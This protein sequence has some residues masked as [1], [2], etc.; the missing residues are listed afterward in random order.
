MKQKKSENQDA[1]ST[2][3]L[4]GRL[5]KNYASD[6]HP[7]NMPKSAQNAGQPTGDDDLDIAELLKKYL[8]DVETS[9][10]SMSAQSDS[11][12]LSGTDR[13]MQVDDAATTEFTAVR[14][15]DAPRHGERFSALFEN[16]DEFIDEPLSA[17]S[18]DDEDKIDAAPAVPAV[19]RQVYHFRPSAHQQTVTQTVKVQET[20]PEVQ[21]SHSAEVVS[22]DSYFTGR[23]KPE[24]AVDDDPV[25]PDASAFDEL[26]PSL[27]SE[28]DAMDAQ[29]AEK[30]EIFTFASESAEETRETSRTE[31]AAEETIRQTSSD[32]AETAE[33]SPEK[34]ELDETDINLMI[35]L[36]Y[37]DE[38]EQTVGIDRVSEIEDK[39]DKDVS[40]DDIDE[41]VAFRGFEYTDKEQ[42]KE[43][44][45]NYRA[46]YSSVLLRLIGSAILLIALFFYENIA[47]FGADLPG[48]LN[49]RHFPTV[50]T[51]VSLQLLVLSAALSWRRIFDGL[52]GAVTFKPSPQSLG[53]AAVVI[54]VAYDLIIAL[55]APANGVILYNFPAALCLTLMALY[56]LMSL[57]REIYSFTILADRHNKYAARSVLAKDAVSGEESLTLDIRLSSFV[58]RYFARTNA[59]TS[60]AN[61]L[62]FVLLPVLVFSV[63]LAIISFSVHKDAIGALNIFALTNLFCLPVSTLIAYSY[64][65]FRASQ[66]AY[67]QDSAILGEVSAEEYSGADVVSFADTDVFP[68]YSVKLRSIK[69]YGNSRPDLVLFAVSG[70]FSAVGGPLA[71]VLELATMEFDSAE[72]VELVRIAEDGIEATVDGQ[73]VMVGRDSFLESYNIHPLH[74][75]EDEA[76]LS[77]GARIL[78]IVMDGALCAKLYIQYEM[79]V[80]FEYALLELT[81]EGITAKIRTYDP[82]I[83]DALLA[84]KL[85]G[86]Q[87]SVQIDK[88]MVPPEEPEPIERIDSGLVSRASAKALVHSALMCSRLSHVERTSSI[89]RGVALAVSLLIMLLLTIFSASIGITSF[90]VALYQLFWMIPGL[91]ITRLLIK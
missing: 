7:T 1:L 41:S 73:S 32:E 52:R 43:I 82:N 23:E 86:K 16:D 10:P 2:G 90:Y 77:C 72:S 39:L 37:E 26:I 42:A 79:D 50:H 70:V 36:G 6:T 28:Q 47:L 85:R 21:A 81:K 8:P 20:I 84:A 75:A 69:L 49:M 12:S 76:N 13:E 58:D 30:T 87:M 35:A 33:P 25:L 4:L 3:E 18:A 74:D 65:L 17:F 15:A 29:P 14:P 53:A 11:A 91:I 5:K 56:D 60:A 34:A 71:D 31:D 45:Q 38:L 78:Y 88:Q 44:M 80:D 19:R 9:K 64:P 66:I 40:G 68:S 55:V 57:K 46:E 63:A 48:A 27:F 62:N 24:F 51:L 67:A 89:I 22:G 54:A 83:D 61:H 59:K